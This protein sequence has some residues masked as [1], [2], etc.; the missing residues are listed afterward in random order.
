MMREKDFQ[1]VGKYHVHCNHVE[2]IY[3]L[4]KDVQSSSLHCYLS[5][6]II[7]INCYY[8]EFNFFFFKTSLIHLVYTEEDAHASCHWFHTLT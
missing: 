6:Q 2:C 3:C 7:T 5:E 1:T 8:V 4:I